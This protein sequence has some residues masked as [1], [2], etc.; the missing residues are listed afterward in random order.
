M[1]TV[2]QAIDVVLD[3]V[4]PLGAEEVELDAAPGRVLARDILADL[5]LPPFDRARM[6]GFAVRS[7]D[8]AS[9]PATLRVIGE[10]AAG[11]SFEGEIKSGQA[12]KI[13]TGAP[14]PRGADSVQ[15]IEITAQSGDHVVINGPVVPGQF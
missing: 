11:A 8:V 13:F 4:G 1:I 6:D 7:A 10:V 15:M 3:R 2:D 14:L 9:V 12:V 5:D